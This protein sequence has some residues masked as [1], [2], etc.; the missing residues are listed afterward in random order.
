[1]ILLAEF[2]EGFGQVK[3]KYQMFS[4]FA[5]SEIAICCPANC[6]KLNRK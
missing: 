2:I 6:A 3:F 4:H 1:M 5:L